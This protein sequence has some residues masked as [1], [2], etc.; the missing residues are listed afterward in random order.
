MRTRK[1]QTIS[2]T[3]LLKLFS[4]EEKSVEW[5]E[6][7]IWNEKPVCPHCKNSNNV[8]IRKGKKFTYRHK[9]CRKE[10]TI[11]TNSTMHG[12]NIPTQLWIIAIYLVNTGRKGISSLQLSKELGVTQKSSWYM[13]QRIRESCKQGEYMLEGFVEIDETYIGGLETNKHKSKQTPNQQGGKGKSIVLGMR[14]RSGNVKAMVIPNASNKT[15][16][17]ALQNNIKRPGTIFT[18]EWR[19]YSE[20]GG[21]THYKVNHSAK[22]YVKVVEFIYDKAH[23]NGIES[24]WALLKRGFHGT[25]HHF[26]KKHLQ[27][28]IDEFAFRLNEGN[29]ERDTIDRIESMVKKTINKRLRYRDLING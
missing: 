5:L 13:L 12:S 18:D 16:T 11:K 25:Y 6:D 3:D 24:V 19:G 1:V 4:T 26:S 23:T 27:R 28:Y 20:I 10:F 17:K 22:E 21:Y 9:E 8:V 2:I 15:L 29:C 14:E 7:K